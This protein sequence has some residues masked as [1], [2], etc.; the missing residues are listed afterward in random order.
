MQRPFKP[1]PGR[2]LCWTHKYGTC[3]VFARTQEEDLEAYLLVFKAM[4]GQSYYWDVGE[5]AEALEWYLKAKD[6]DGTAAKCLLE[7]RS[8]AGYQYEGLSIE[9]IDTPPS[10]QPKLCDHLSDPSDPDDPLP[11]HIIE[12]ATRYGENPEHTQALLDEYRRGE[13]ITVTLYPHYKRPPA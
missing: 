5:D 10:K 12:L 8:A 6:G 7:V 2:V 1:S 4:D 13:S 3:L 11:P 9:R